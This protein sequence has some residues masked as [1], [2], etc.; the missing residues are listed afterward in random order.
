MNENIPGQPAA[1]ASV[2]LPGKADAEGWRH[3]HPLSPLLRGGLALL[4]IIGIVVANMRDRVIQFFMS[5]AFSN[6]GDGLPPEVNEYSGDPI[7][8]IV[9]RS[10]VP[11]AL[12][13]VLVVVLLIVLFSWVVWKFQTYRITADTV[14]ERSGVLSKKHR[15][16]PLERVQ[17]VNLQRSLFA[18]ILGLAKVEVV[19]AGQGGKVELSYLSF[20]D[21]KLV[22]GEILRRAAAA[23][24]GSGAQVAGGPQAAGGATAH[25]VVAAGG[26]G[27]G[28]VAQQAP[29][30]MPVAGVPLAGDLHAG[31][32]EAATHASTTDPKLLSAAGL[33][34][35]VDQILDADIAPEAIAEQTLVKVPVGRL[36]ASILL[37]WE[38]IML[39][40]FVL[41]A[42]G[43]FVFGAFKFLF[44]DDTGVAGIAAG[45]AFAAG[46]LVIVFATILISQFNKG[47]GFTLSRGADS[48][49]IGAGLTSTV[50]E[51][52][53]FGKVHA[54]EARQPLFWRPIGWWKVRITLAG[55]SVAQGG[56]NATTQNLVLPVGKLEDVIRVIE[57]I[58]P[59][60]GGEQAAA[61]II[62]GLVGRGEGYLGAGPRSAPVLWFGKRRA[63]VRIETAGAPTEVS[64]T[65]SEGEEATLRIR[66]G[67]LNR[68]LVIMPLVRAQSVQ[69]R[70]PV[71]H[72]FLGLASVQ[73]H[74]VLGPVR[75]EMRG[76]AEADARVLF[77]DLE[78]AVL[79]AQL[80]DSRQRDALRGSHA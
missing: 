56:Q 65:A 53:P 20:A 79:A 36:I 63:G 4:V 72:R 16:A 57:T 61:G 41:L 67:A 78:H 8:F 46:P 54:V 9:A 62:D 47:Y 6:G 22:R 74:T 29:M 12:G 38:S 52:I 34:D 15:R 18:R 73:A 76:L 50:T 39:I 2:A 71:V 77:A 24:G 69:F 58:M 48:V 68:V 27:V 75:V 42:V 37:G 26:A 19:T 55:Q 33:S 43:G 51:S 11:I 31:S 17:S 40:L 3:L 70:Q 21:S 60:L 45:L 59:G 13:G 10:L 7:D 44:S 25:G 5:D 66:R 30:G 23:R 1:P 49:R 35:R 28:P 32:G 80:Q 64:T 14:E